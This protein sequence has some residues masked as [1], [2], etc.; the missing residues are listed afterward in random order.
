MRWT[1]TVVATWHRLNDIGPDD[2]AII[3]GWICKKMS[4]GF[5]QISDQVTREAHSTKSLFDLRKGLE[6]KMVFS[7]TVYRI[8][9]LQR[10][11]HRQQIYQTE[12][13]SLE[14]IVNNEFMIFDIRHRHIDTRRLRCPI[15]HSMLELAYLNSLLLIK[16]S[17]NVHLFSLCPFASAKCCYFF[18]SAL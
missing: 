3:F 15:H 10:S 12:K 6:T 4:V 13:H 16:H 2:V 11:R 9:A 8:A 14:S 17:L 18:M 7:L 5:S 1:P